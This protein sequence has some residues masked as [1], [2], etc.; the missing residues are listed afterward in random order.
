[1]IASLSAVAFAALLRSARFHQGFIAFNVNKR[2]RAAAIIV[3][4]RSFASKFLNVCAGP[5]NDTA[6][7]DRPLS[8]KSRILPQE[9]GGLR[10][11][12]CKNLSSN[13]NKTKYDE[14]PNSILTIFA[15]FGGQAVVRMHQFPVSPKISAIGGVVI[16]WK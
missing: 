5:K 3:W 12:R 13:F 15:G 11:M 2:G 4:D 14:I 8:R 1:L 9:I 10:N 16:E 6:A 7:L